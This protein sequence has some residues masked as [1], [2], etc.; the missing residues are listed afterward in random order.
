MEIAEDIWDKVLDYVHI[1]AL[2]ARKC[3]IKFNILH[4]L[5]YSKVKLH[6]IFPEISQICEICAEAEFTS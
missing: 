3:L 1:C 4:R 2:N 6:E 5:H